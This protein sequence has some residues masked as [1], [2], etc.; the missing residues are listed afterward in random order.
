MTDFGIEESFSGAAVRM[1]EHH[2]V[3]INVSAIRKVTEMHAERAQD[4]MMAFAQEKRSVTQMVLEM[5]GEM[6]PLVEY[7]KVC[8]QRREKTLLWAELRVGAAQRHGE[9]EWKY[10]TSFKNA[11][12]LGDRMRITMQKMGMNG[13][14]PK[15]WVA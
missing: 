10:A 9:V 6:V 8:D 13:R 2:G 5:D 12:E 15:L 11:E 3:N 1:K 7:R 14:I 4:I